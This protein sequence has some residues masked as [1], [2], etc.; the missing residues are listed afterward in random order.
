MRV[1]AGNACNLPIQQWQPPRIPI[2][3][4]HADGVL[5]NALLL[6]MAFSTECVQGTHQLGRILLR[7]N[8]G[9]TVG[10]FF[11]DGARDAADH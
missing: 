4:R 7:L 5:G 1:M 8:I 9:M 6:N 10:A 11:M 3:W 2:L